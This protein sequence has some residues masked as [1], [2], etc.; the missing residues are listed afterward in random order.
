METNHILSTRYVTFLKNSSQHI[1]LNLYRDRR[2]LLLFFFNLIKY[3]TWL[4]LNTYIGLSC[5]PVNILLYVFSFVYMITK[6]A[7]F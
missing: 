6:I 4:M 2:F 1:H 3:D 7:E 5:V